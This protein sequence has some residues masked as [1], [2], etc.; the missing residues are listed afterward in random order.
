MSGRVTSFVIV[1]ASALLLASGA[2]HARVRE[3]SFKAEKVEFRS[4]TPPGQ[5][6]GDAIDVEATL[7]LPR[8]SR[9]PVGLVIIAPSSSGIEEERE[10]YY[11]RELT[12]AGIAALVLDSFG[13]RDLQGSL[14]DQSILTEW[15]IELDAVGALEKLR[16]DKRINRNRI[17][18][19]GVS[20]GGTVAMNTAFMVRRRWA[21]V[22]DSQFAAHIAISPD[23]TW[24]TRNPK[25]TGAPIR[26][27][28]AALDDQTP[29][30]PC[31]EL[32]NRIRAEGNST[33]E[34]TVYEG[35]HHAWEE[36]GPTPEY[37]AKVENYAKCSVWIE[38]DGRMRS[39][40][41]GE[42]V[43]EDTW[44]NWAKRNCM[45]LGASCCGGT[46][47]LKAR[48]TADLI[49]FLRRHGF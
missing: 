47:E 14:Y 6:R 11:A 43:P 41:T 40:E 9:S 22:G 2:F 18:I 29:A 39:V 27:L 28:L 36:L 12:K 37:D 46:P 26:F 35:A 23:C 31:I 3:T 19:L 10:V 5:S 45:T 25:T 38:D 34:T 13:S 30:R 32:A 15:E 48:A 20:K 21:G 16:R 33:V 8:A 44:H 49:D 4:K 1:L 24:V 17:A 42:L 7:Y